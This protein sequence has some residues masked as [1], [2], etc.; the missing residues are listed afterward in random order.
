[1]RCF[2]EDLLLPRQWWWTAPSQDSFMVRLGKRVYVTWM[3]EK[4]RMSLSLYLMERG[5]GCIHLCSTLD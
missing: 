5:K 4:G 2:Q 3:G 1:M